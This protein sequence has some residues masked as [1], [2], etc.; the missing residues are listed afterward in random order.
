M[1]GDLPGWGPDR[2]TSEPKGCFPA[3]YSQGP[4][5]RPVR[6]AQYGPE[7]GWRR[8]DV[9]PEDCPRNLVCETINGSRSYLTRSIQALVIYGSLEDLA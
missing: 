7:T 6:E 5:E 3:H 8:E 2:P 9:N 4:K 1:L